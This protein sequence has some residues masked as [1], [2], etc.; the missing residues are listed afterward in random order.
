MLDLPVTVNCAEIKLTVE[1]SKD[2][3]LRLTVKDSVGN[4]GSRKFIINKA[5]NIL[6]CKYNKEKLEFSLDSKNLKDGLTYVCFDIEG[7]STGIKAQY[8]YYLPQV[9]V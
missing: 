8:P 9:K 3:F 6:S 7:Q 1:R 5:I 4:T 2:V